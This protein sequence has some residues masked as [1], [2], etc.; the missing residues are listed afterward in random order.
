MYSRLVTK[1]KLQ[2]NSKGLYTNARF[3]LFVGS[4]VKICHFVN[5]S[6]LQESFAEISLESGVIGYRKLSLISPGL[7]NL[8]KGF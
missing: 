8:R 6:C 4:E 3:S 5:Y 2:I 1:A 7:K